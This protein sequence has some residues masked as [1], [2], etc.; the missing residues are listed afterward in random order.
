MLAVFQINFDY[1][2][3]Q[4][5]I[6]LLTDFDTS[7]VSWLKSGGK[8]KIDAKELL[9]QALEHEIDHLNGILFIDHLKEHEKL[10]QA[11][12]ENVNH[13][14]DI[15]LSINID[16]KNEDKFDSK[17]YT[18]IGLDDLKLALERADILKEVEGLK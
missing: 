2:M 10:S 13:S 17:L 11:T 12:S 3:N 6:N 16:K 14:H 7:K 4:E 15:D 9:S 5:K 18:K 1:I 8:I